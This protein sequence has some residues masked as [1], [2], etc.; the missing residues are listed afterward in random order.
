[1]LCLSSLSAL[2]HLEGRLVV[3]RVYRCT[4]SV[5]VAMGDRFACESD[6]S[7]SACSTPRFRAQAAR[8]KMTYISALAVI[9]RKLPYGYMTA[10]IRSNVLNADHNGLPRP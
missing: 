8:M 6:P 1:M 4:H 7:F 2:D 3:L 9:A 5:G 10:V